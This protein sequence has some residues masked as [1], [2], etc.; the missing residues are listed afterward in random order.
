MFRSERWDEDAQ[1]RLQRWRCP[2]SAASGGEATTVVPRL[3]DAP[4]R[5]PVCAT[6]SATRDTR[7]RHHRRRRR[8]KSAETVHATPAGELPCE[9]TQ[10]GLL[11]AAVGTR[12]HPASHL[13]ELAGAPFYRVF[14][15][16][17]DVDDGG[18]Q[19]EL[20]VLAQPL[21]LH[22]PRSIRDRAVQRGR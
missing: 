16:V 4:V 12:P 9:L 15:P 3:I 7:G 1:T 20:R 21:P 8:L 10:C 5:G 19:Q 2:T 11:T 18:V 22:G 14:P 17:V 6:A 13:R